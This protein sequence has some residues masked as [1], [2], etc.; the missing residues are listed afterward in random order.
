VGGST[1]IAQGLPTLS[2]F[3]QPLVL[4]LRRTSSFDDRLDGVSPYQRI[5]AANHVIDIRYSR[6]WWDDRLTTVE[7]MNYLQWPAMAV[8]L[9]SAW[10]VAA[11]SKK[12][13]QWGFW[14]FL[15]SNILWAAWGCYAKAYAIILL[16]IGLAALNIRGAAKND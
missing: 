6:K 1:I 4:S 7:W 16:Q 5:I 10:F 8:T 2:R 12:W 3:A 11:Q 13:R 9:L 15:L 14:F